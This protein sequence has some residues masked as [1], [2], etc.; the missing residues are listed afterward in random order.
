MKV[1]PECLSCLF[2]RAIFEADLALNDDHKK[3]AFLKELLRFASDNFDLDATP[4]MIGTQRERILSRI[5]G[6]ADP[7]LELKRKSNAVAVRLL[8]LAREAYERSDD[9][10]RM[11]LAIAAAGNSMEYGVRGHV[12]DHRTFS[13]EFERL[14]KEPI[15]GDVEAVLDAIKRSSKV[16]Y[17]TDNAGEIVFDLFLIKALIERGKKVVISPKSS[18]IM[19]D[20]TVDD[21]KQYA[22]VDLEVV[23]S[24]SFIGLSLDEANEDLLKV[25]WDETYLV[26]A[27]GMGNYEM[28][29]EFENRL[30]DRLIYIFRAKC[31]PVARSVGVNQGEL[32][33][34]M[35]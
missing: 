4:A 32:V 22:D 7:Y 20:A 31:I 18:P 1:R 28:V 13:P 23:P 26:I 17:L 35:R 5:S 14:L 2:D 12:F 9:K 21:V 29:S 16:L 33:A 24:G 6:D 15:V 11:L 27:K 19:N 3:I 8:E 25:L 34:V 10:L 30:K